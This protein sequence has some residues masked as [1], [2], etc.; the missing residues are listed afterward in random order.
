MARSPRKTKTG[1]ATTPGSAA[2][3]QSTRLLQRKDTT[4]T[5]ATAPIVTQPTLSQIFEMEAVA[6]AAV[7][8]EIVPK[9]KRCAKG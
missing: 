6:G 7:G 1:A 5:K 9:G 2:L 8:A 3:R 4:S